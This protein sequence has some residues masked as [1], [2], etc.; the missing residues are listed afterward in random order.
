M[1]NMQVKS[2]SKRFCRDHSLVS[3]LYPPSNHDFHS[4]SSSQHRYL[5]IATDGGP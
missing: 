2:D 3:S 1:G 5:I 4:L